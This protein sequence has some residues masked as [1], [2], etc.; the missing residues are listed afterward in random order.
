MLFHRT[1]PNQLLISTIR[2]YEK[3]YTTGIKCKKSTVNEWAKSVLLN[4]YGFSG[5]SA[6]RPHMP[7]MPHL[8]GQ[9]NK[10]LHLMV[11]SIW[12]N[13]HYPIIDIDSE[14]T[15]IRAGLWLEEQNITYSI[16]KSANNYWFI[17]D[18]PSSFYKAKRLAKLVPGN[19]SDYI[20]HTERSFL[21]RMSLKEGS[22][23]LPKI[24]SLGNESADFV[25]AIDK[26]LKDSEETIRFVDRYAQYHEGG[27]DLDDAGANPF[28][29]TVESILGTS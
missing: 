21:L 2:S 29:I 12:N 19:D 22:N 27:I 25:N 11:S 9:L 10:K 13:K 14:K 5:F 4:K 15:M 17:L 20:R 1:K 3:T 24:L 6:N 7:A 16:M 23:N 18:R 8:G 28:N 26:F